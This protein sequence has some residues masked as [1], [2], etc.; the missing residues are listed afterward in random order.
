MT[1]VEEVCELFRSEGH[2]ATADVAMTIRHGRTRIQE[3]FAVPGIDTVAAADACTALFLA[4][5]A[6]ALSR[7][8]DA[9]LL[10]VKRVRVVRALGDGGQGG[11]SAEV[12]LDL[13]GPHLRRT[14]QVAVEG[15]A[16]IEDAGERARRQVAEIADGLR[17]LAA[18][19]L[20]GAAALAAAAGG[21]SVAS[22]V[23]AAR[24]APGLLRLGLEVSGAAAAGQG[25]REPVP[26]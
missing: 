18:P 11:T 14:V 20:A 26:A 5:Y 22:V 7:I 3:S 12:E 13:M 8:H 10:T 15:C 25:T 6:E 17:G 4:G 16:G 9:G 2:P 19:R 23:E 1:T 24:P 21:A